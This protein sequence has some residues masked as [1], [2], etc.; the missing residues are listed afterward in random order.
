VHVQQ[1]PSSSDGSGVGWF[2][3]RI[4]VAGPE[5][6][7]WQFPCSAWLGRSNHPSGL[8]GEPPPA[9]AACWEG[10]GEVGGSPVRL[11]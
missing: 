10:G 1:L 3:D 7:H 6:Q 11:V 8:D 2:L 4:E 5:G 9:A